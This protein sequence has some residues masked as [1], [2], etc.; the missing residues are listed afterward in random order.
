MDKIAESEIRRLVEN[1]PVVFSEKLHGT[2][3]NFRRAFRDS[4]TENVDYITFF[5]QHIKGINENIAAHEGLSDLWIFKGA[6]VESRV[7]SIRFLSDDIA[8]V[9]STGGIRMRWQKKLSP[10]RLSIQTLVAVRESG[11]WKI[12]AFQNSRI[13]KPGLMQKLFTRKK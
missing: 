4:Y 1:L 9:H 5:G 13:K 8:L 6:V 12:T 11:K 3:E 2:R 10:S 7:I